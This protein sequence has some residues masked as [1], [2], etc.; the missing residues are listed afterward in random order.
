MDS[1]TDTQT[2]KYTDEQATH[3]IRQEILGKQFVPLVGVYRSI[4]EGLQDIGKDQR[5]RA[6]K[7]I[8]A[9]QDNQPIGDDHKDMNLDKLLNNLTTKD[10]RDAS[11]N[12]SQAASARPRAYKRTPDRPHDRHND[13]SDGGD[14]QWP[15][16]FSMYKGSGDK[17]GGGEGDDEDVGI[18]LGRRRGDDQDDHNDSSE[19][20]LVHLRNI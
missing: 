13:N 9:Q 7:Q 8:N 2:D 1:M 5:Q 10:K 14:E 19:F 12:H 15:S 20:T 4:S 6:L 3:A 18:G 17:G 16:L 11:D